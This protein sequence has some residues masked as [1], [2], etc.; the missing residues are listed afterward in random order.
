MAIWL[1]S[2]LVTEKGCIENCNAAHRN[3]AGRV[4][5]AQMSHGDRICHRTKE[6]LLKKLEQAKKEKEGEAARAEEL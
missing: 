1:P 5:C 4:W 2:E 6:D 3:S